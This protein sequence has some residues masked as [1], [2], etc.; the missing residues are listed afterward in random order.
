MKR[1][2]LFTTALASAV[3]LFSI[4]AAQASGASEKG[5]T[6]NSSEYRYLRTLGENNEQAQRNEN[7]ER[8][9]YRERNEKQERNEN[10]TRD[11]DRDHAENDD[12][13]DD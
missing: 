6:R 3:G 9:E 1:T 13:S 8:H 7:R 5:E 11:A 2:I 12:S 4:G 10:R